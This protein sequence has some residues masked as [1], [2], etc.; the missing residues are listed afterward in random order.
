MS[1][2]RNFTRGQW[3][4]F[5]RRL[6][7]LPE[8]AKHDQPVKVGDGVKSIWT[9]IV[10]AREK[11]YTMPE[12]IEQAAQEGIDV[13]L[14]SLRYAMRCA[15][16]RGRMRR[17]SRDASREPVTPPPRGRKSAQGEAPLEE[18]LRAGIHPKGEKEV[19]KPEQQVQGFLGFPISSDTENL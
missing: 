5:G 14:N 19:T 6:N 17:G 9:Q 1:D 8:K 11:G 7:A 2:V 16:G 3:E 10:A 4:A 15:D 13:S 12:L 18:P